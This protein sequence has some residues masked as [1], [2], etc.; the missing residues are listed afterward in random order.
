MSIDDVWS[1]Y[2]VDLSKK[3]YN[4]KHN[5]DNLILTFIFLY[6]INAI[7]QKNGLIYRCN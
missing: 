7:E 2:Q 3:N 6:G 4:A 5:F 1:T